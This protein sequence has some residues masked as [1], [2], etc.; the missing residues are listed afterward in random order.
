M[1]G[2][3]AEAVQDHTLLKPNLPW[4]V[5]KEAENGFAFGQALAKRDSEFSLLSDILDAAQSAGTEATSFFLGGY[6]REMSERTLSFYRTFST[7]ISSDDRLSHLLIELTWRSGT[8]D[9]AVMR[10]V[11]LAREKKV[12][13]LEF[14]LLTFGRAVSALDR[15]LVK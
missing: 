7:S 11:K 2:L 3:A 5:T 6:L 14:R 8:N 13:P 4:L 12:N 9:D 10:L 15:C 1:A